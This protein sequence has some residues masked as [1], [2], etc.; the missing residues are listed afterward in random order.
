M[1]FFLLK[2]ILYT[3]CLYVLGTSIENIVERGLKLTDFGII[4]DWNKI[5]EGDINDEVIILGSSRA[6]DHLDPRIFE[7]T[8]KMTCYNLGIIG[9]RS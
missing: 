7:H 6:V 9:K 8:V 4:G 2:V 5:F 3:A 1:R